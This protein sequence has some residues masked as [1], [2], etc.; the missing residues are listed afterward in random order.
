MKKNVTKKELI[1]EIGKLKAQNKELVEERKTIKNWF[2]LNDEEENFIE[3]IYKNKNIINLTK[4]I[5]Y[6]LVL[7]FLCASCYLLGLMR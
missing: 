1:E 6:I 5:C 4:R 7:L 3:I 2:S